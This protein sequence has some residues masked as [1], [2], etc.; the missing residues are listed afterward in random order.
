[1]DEVRLWNGARTQSEI[2]ATINQQITTAQSDLV[3]RWALDE[4]SGTTVSGSAGTAWTGTV[5]GANYAWE[6][7]APFSMSPNQP[8]VA[9]GVVGQRALLSWV[10]C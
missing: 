1:M 10:R 4:G 2:Q 3:A 9:S 8:P 7:G 6:V 5:V